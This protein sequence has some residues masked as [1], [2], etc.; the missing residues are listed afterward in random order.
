MNKNFYVYQLIDPRDSLIFYVGKGK[1]DRMYHHL[2]NYKNGSLAKKNT[3]L[4]L[5]IIKQLTN[6][7]FSIKKEGTIY[8]L[9]HRGIDWNL[10]FRSNNSPI[11]VDQYK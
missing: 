4:F 11:S 1:D 7:H 8:E 9:Q 10:W 2:Q 6:K 5:K 3:K